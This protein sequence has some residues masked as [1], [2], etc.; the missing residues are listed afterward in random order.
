LAGKLQLAPVCVQLTLVSYND[1]QDDD[2][3][4]VDSAELA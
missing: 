1:P 4:T 2:E 3:Q